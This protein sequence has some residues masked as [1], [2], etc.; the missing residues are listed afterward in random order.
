MVNDIVC[1]SV[2]VCV[3]VWCVCV[4]VCVLEQHGQW[5]AFT[6][7]ALD[8]LAGQVSLLDVTTIG[9]YYTTGGLMHPQPQYPELRRVKG[10]LLSRQPNVSNASFLS[11]DLG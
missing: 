6:N 4:C 1:V 10:P 9:V 11:T 5:M 3:C 7:I 2:C 8:S